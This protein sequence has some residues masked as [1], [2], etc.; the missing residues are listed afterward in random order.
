[1][2]NVNLS[3]ESFISNLVKGLLENPSV[4]F[5]INS[6]DLKFILYFSYGVVNR[7]FPTSVGF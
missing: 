6:C 7:P 5:K 2:Q 3:S 4:G 1:M